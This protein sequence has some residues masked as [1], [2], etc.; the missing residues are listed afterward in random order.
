MRHGGYKKTDSHKTDM[1]PSH[2]KMAQP[3]DE[4]YVL[5]S[6]VRT[7]R[8]IRGYALAPV[9]N[10]YER[11]MVEKII[12]DACS[13]YAGDLAGTYKGLYDMTEK[14]HEDLI[15]A[16]LMFEKPVSPLLT[17]SGMA[18]DWPD[19]RGVFLNKDRSLIVWI[20]EE[21]HMRIVSMQKGGDMKAVFDRFC[22]ATN[23]MEAT[24]KKDNR[25]FMHSDHLGF[26]LTCPSNLGTGLRAGV[27]V[28]IPKFSARPDFKEVLK[29]LKLQAR[30]TGGVDTAA[31]G[32]VYDLSN[33]FR[34]GYSEVELVQTV[35]DGVN[36]LV[37]WEKKLEK[38]ESIDGEVSKL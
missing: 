22:R 5:S 6:R 25:E 31:T 8:S 13:K 23:E 20:N 38:G 21:D 1:D 18:R 11:R 10:R 3:F 37:E 17:A 15:E 30:G 34:L 12:V 28:K 4:K 14:E 19:A 29:K 16:H 7:G 9:I 32:G 26:I 27:H 24:M 2:V 36:T 35:I 33:S